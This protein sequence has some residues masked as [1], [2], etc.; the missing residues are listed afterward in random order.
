[1]RELPLVFR[2]ASQQGRR[3]QP[4][5]HLLRPAARARLDSLSHIDQPHRPVGRGNQRVGQH[6]VTAELQGSGQV[7]GA[8]HHLP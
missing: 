6:P 5:Q 2:Q 8:L 4:P 3:R 7:P 1:M